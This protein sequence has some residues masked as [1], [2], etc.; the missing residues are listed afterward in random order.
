MLDS[1]IIS[2]LK[3]I[4]E[5]ISKEMMQQ[6]YYF[7]PSHCENKWKTLKRNYRL[8]QHFDR[9]GSGGK[10]HCAFER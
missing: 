6:Q 9:F 5:L 2:T 1:G 8:K 3:K 4:W 7:S 10:R